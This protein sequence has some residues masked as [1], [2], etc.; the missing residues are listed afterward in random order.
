[1]FRL[2]PP[3]RYVP[4]SSAPAGQPRPRAG[5]QAARPSTTPA[6]SARVRP[7][8]T[9]AEPVAP[10]GYVQVG[11]DPHLYRLAGAAQ[12]PTHQQRTHTETSSLRT[13]RTARQ[14][15]IRT[16]LE[17]RANSPLQRCLIIKARFSSAV[18]SSELF[19]GPRD[20][21]SSGSSSAL[22]AQSSTLGITS[23]NL[24]PTRRPRTTLSHGA[25]SRSR[26]TA[27]RLYECRS[28]AGL[29]LPSAVSKSTSATEM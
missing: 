5:E 28:V 2:M 10:T 21:A 12:T 11:L 24:Q 19:V 26:G 1:M 3:A 16:V 25:A 17:I 9:H 22:F 4:P 23:P 13:S 29:G 15:S 18:R 27:H 14:C 7:K 6:G 20:L 8:G